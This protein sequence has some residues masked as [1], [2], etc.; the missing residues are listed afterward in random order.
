EYRQYGW[1]FPEKPATRIGQMEDAIQLVKTMW[2]EPRATYHGKY[3]RVENA[4]LEPKPVQKPH[5]PIM[6][7]GGGEQLTLRAVAR[8]GDAC[9]IF[10]D[11]ATVKKKFD[12]LRRHC[13]KVERDYNEIEKTNL[14]SFLIAPDETALQAKKERL[15]VAGGFRGHAL[16]PAQTVDLIGKY[17]DVGVQMVVFSAYKNDRETLELFASDVISKF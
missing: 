9:N 8:H 5:P 2:R 7:G 12:V 6:I 15:G 4:I 16:T 14:T 10:G 17:R 11:P 1:D 3:F 13:D